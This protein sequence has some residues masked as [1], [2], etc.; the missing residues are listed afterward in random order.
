MKRDN[1]SSRN[2]HATVLADPQFRSRATK[3]SKERA[4]QKDGWDREAKH[5]TRQDDD[6][7][8]LQLGDRIEY[9]GKEGMVKTPNGPADLVGI[10]IDGDY[11][12]VPIDKLKVIEESLA[13][14]REL[15]R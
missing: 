4:K 12:L 10:G 7:P 9:E 11:K 15:S 6:A 8:T 1:T 13:R 3:T 5:K 14:L 2:P